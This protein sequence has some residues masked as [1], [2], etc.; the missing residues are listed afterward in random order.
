MVYAGAEYEVTTL[1]RLKEVQEQAAAAKVKV[2]EADA[3]DAA[4]Q[5]IEDF[6]VMLSS[7]FCALPLHL[8]SSH[9]CG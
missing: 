4:V 3:L 1:E 8:V 6:Q 5:L 2:A 7:V 9:P